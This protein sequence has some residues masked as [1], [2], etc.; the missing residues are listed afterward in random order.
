MK[1]GGRSPSAG[2]RVGSSAVRRISSVSIPYR[3]RIG[4][5]SA[6]GSRPAAVGA[7][8]APGALGGPP[9]RGRVDPV[10]L[11]DRV[12]LGQGQPLDAVGVRAAVADPVVVHELDP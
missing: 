1:G 10:P 11:A 8:G 5:A 9:G 3:W 6:R 7:G 2:W 4:S 12:V